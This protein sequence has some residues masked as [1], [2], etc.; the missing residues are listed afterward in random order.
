MIKSGGYQ[1]GL[2]YQRYRAFGHGPLGACW[3]V[4]SD[5]ILFLVCA[6]LVIELG[7]L[8]GLLL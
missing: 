8:V 3:M 1:S 4:N 7:V 2:T 5:R 6:V